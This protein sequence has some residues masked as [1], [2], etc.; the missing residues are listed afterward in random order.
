MIN[1]HLKLR[2]F[3]TLRAFCPLSLFLLLF[4]S[5]LLYTK[6]S[7]F[8]TF[9]TFLDKILR[10]WTLILDSS[11]ERGLIAICKDEELVFSKHLSFGLLHSKNFFSCLIEGLKSA[12]IEIQDL[13]RIALAAG[14]GSYTGLRVAAMMA[15]AFSF[16]AKI[17]LWGYC[18]LEALPPPEAGTFASVLDAK[19]AGVYCIK[20]RKTSHGDLFFSSPQKI[21]QKE[22]AQELQGLD[23]LLSPNLK[24]LLP[25]FEGQLDADL[26]H[27]TA[28]CPLQILGR[29]GQNP[30]FLSPSDRGEIELLYLE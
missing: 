16:L 1:K 30:N 26:W 12:S 29:L 21:S 20:G 22:A 7:A 17:P 8:L 2:V 14:P 6:T 5:I 28:P 27:E 18:S 9:K 24:F 10:M 25:K 13:G 4:A 23:Y 3:T 15:K 11:H 19:S